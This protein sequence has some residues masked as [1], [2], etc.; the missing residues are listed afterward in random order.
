MAEREVQELV[1]KTNFDEITKAEKAYKD[2]MKTTLHADTALGKSF[3]ATKKLIEAERKTIE[4]SLKGGRSSFSVTDFASKALPRFNLPNINELLGNGS[5]MLSDKHSTD[6]QDQIKGIEHSLFKDL[7]TGAKD[8]KDLMSTLKI[9]SDSFVGSLVNGLAEGETILK[10]IA[11][12]FNS[13]SS[14]SKGFGILGDFVSLL[15]FDSGGY[16]GSGDKRSI[17]GF[18]HKGEFVWDSETTSKFL[19]LLDSIHKSKFDLSSFKLGNGFHASQLSGLSNLP[20]IN[21]NYMPVQTRQPDNI[22]HVHLHGTL[23][24]Q[25]F[26]RTHLPKYLIREA[27]IRA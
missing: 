26:L 22:I 14:I 18:V 4:L 6:I 27:S 23:E 21:H 13:V 8:L 19:P 15:G 10:D 16:T 25:R 9:G 11:G 20:T 24:G 2:F 3:E 7:D 17:A 12:V 5:P 1:I